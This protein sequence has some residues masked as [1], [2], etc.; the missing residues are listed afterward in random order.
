MFDEVIAA[1][2]RIEHRDEM[3]EGYRRTCGRQIAQPAPSE[4]IGTQP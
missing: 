4:T 2:G 3:P 1:D